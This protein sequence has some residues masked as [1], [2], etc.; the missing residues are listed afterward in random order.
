VCQGDDAGEALEVLDHLEA[1]RDAVTGVLE[2]VSDGVEAV[3]AREVGDERSRNGGGHVAGGF[4]ERVGAGVD[5]HRALRSVASQSRRG[6][7]AGAASEVEPGARRADDRHGER[8][9]QL[10]LDPDRRRGLAGD[11]LLPFHGRAAY[12]QPA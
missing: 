7:H 10:V 4:G 3:R 5:E 2:R 8:V 9:A 6:G 12:T 11:A 1:G